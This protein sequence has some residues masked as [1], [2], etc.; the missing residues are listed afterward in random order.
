MQCRASKVCFLQF[1][2]FL[3]CPC[4]EQACDP[5]R[6]PK[7]NISIKSK[8]V[9]VKTSCVKGIAG[10]SIQARDIEIFFWVYHINCAC[11]FTKPFFFWPS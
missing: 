8:V 1:C 3:T 4:G 7:W 11:L 6:H 2:I 9:C 10:N 5:P